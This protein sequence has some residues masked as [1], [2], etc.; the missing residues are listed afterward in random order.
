[1]WATVT[2]GTQLSGLVTG[3][4]ERRVPWSS[5]LGNIWLTGRFTAGLLNPSRADVWR[6]HSGRPFFYKLLG[7]GSISRDKKTPDWKNLGQ[8]SLPLINIVLF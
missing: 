5:D 7:S 6:Q 2:H 4:P 3:V 1:M 8:N